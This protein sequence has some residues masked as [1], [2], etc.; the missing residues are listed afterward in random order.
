M[1][2][3]E[4]KTKTF[5]QLYEIARP[6]LSIDLPPNDLLIDLATSDTSDV[7]ELT[8]AV[9]DASFILECPVLS[10]LS[11]SDYALFDSFLNDVFPSAMSSSTAF[12]E[13]QEAF[14]ATLNCA[15]SVH[16][17]ASDSASVHSSHMRYLRSVRAIARVDAKSRR[18][19][20]RS[21]LRR[22]KWREGLWMSR[23]TSAG[24]ARAVSGT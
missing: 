11:K 8:D 3:N 14:V 16:E 23:Y 9:V 18:L 10:F 15:Q 7:T 20:T 19:P 17:A 12:G 4:L 5:L 24:N 21:S 2:L 1:L 22:Q 6:L 13:F